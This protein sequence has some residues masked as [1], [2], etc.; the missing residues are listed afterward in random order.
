MYGLRNHVISGSVFPL[1]FFFIRQS[2]FLAVKPPL[3]LS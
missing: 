2:L 3:Y 1:I